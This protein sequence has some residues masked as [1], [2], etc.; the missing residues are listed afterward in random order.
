MVLA[1]IDPESQMTALQLAS[2]ERRNDIVELMLKLVDLLPEVNM[3]EVIEDAFTIALASG[4]VNTIVVLATR[5][6]GLLRRYDNFLDQVVHIAKVF[7][8][9]PSKVA[10]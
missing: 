8:H 6:E 7:Y 2:R 9:R 10:C 5:C 3:S 4:H 1:Y